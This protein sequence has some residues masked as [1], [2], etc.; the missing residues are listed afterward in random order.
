MSKDNQCFRLDYTPE[1]EKL[2]LL[3]RLSLVENANTYTPKI[4][5]WGRKHPHLLIRILSERTYQE[6]ARD[7]YRRTAHGA[8]AKAIKEWRD[9]ESRPDC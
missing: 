5:T 8:I 3:I 4:L 2:C 6:W 1:L 9:R 7:C